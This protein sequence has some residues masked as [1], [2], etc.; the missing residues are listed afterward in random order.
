MTQPNPWMVFPF[1]LLLALIALGPLFFADR[2]GR[3]YP[4]ACFGLG[5][6]VVVYYLLDLHAGERVVEVGFDYLRFLALIGSLF[7]V[8]GGIHITVKGEA[9]PLANVVFLLFGAL[10]SNLIGTTGASMLLIRPWLRVNKYRVTGHHV[11]FFIFVVSNVGGC[12]TPV[13]DPPLYLGYLKG[14]PFWWVTEHCWPAWTVG[15]GVLLALFYLV[16]ERNYRRAPREVRE[17]L[18][19]PA[20]QWRFDG[21]SNL[22]FLGVIL[23]AAFIERPLFLREILMIGS[24]AGSYFTTSRQAHESNNFNFH[25]IKEVAILFAG[26]FATMMPALD[27]LQGNAGKLG[28]PTPAFFYFGSGTLSS[29]LDNAPTYLAFLSAVFGSFI[30]QEMVAQVQHVVQT[31]GVDLASLTGPKVEQ[32]RHTFAALQKYHSAAVASGNVSVGD[33]S[34]CFLLGNAAYHKFILAISVGSV[35]FGANTYIGNGPNFMVKAIAD[36]NKVR[37]PTFTGYIAKY[38]LPFM[39]PMLV[40]VWWVFFRG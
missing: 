33:I 12:L 37:T 32:I 10:T 6:V 3:H 1:G 7:V 22:V 25:P 24:A 4:K 23:L 8:A 15:V 20:D 35:F 34:I 29:V 16:D 19:E 18:A 31:H 17:Q 2:W 39:L 40:I 28:E 13:G 27:W 14:I 30:N 11:V 5:V 36:Q 38:T 9:T 26:I 21:L